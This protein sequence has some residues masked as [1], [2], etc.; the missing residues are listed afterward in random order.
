MWSTRSSTRTLRPSNQLATW[1]A[2]PLF[3]LY[4]CNFCSCA[5][6]GVDLWVQ[7]QKRKPNN[8][9]KYTQIQHKAPQTF[10]GYLPASALHQFHRSSITRLSSLFI[11]QV[12]NSC[13]Y[14]WCVSYFLKMLICTQIFSLVTYNLPI[15][16]APTNGIL[17]RK[18]QSI[19]SFWHH[20][21]VFVHDCKMLKLI[22]IIKSIAFWQHCTNLNCY[23]NS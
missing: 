20:C 23:W 21:L 8:V 4:T 10:S 3:W 17:N 7:P 15:S 1:K 22:I 12:S 6:L 16:I 11:Y 9:E 2:Y 14:W 18:T 19:H 5:Y 13:K